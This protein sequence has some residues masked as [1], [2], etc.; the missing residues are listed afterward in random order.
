MIMRNDPVTKDTKK[1]R[2]YGEIALKVVRY[3]LS[4]TYRFIVRD[5]VT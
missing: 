4:A 3:T 5:N 2:V 1:V